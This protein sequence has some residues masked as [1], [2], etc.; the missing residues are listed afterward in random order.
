MLNSSGP[1]YFITHLI[2]HIFFTST[3]AFWEILNWVKQ[4]RGVWLDSEG[5]PATQQRKKQEQEVWSEPRLAPSALAETDVGLCSVLVLNKHC[6][7]HVYALIYLYLRIQ[8]PSVSG[9]WSGSTAWG[10]KGLSYTHA[11]F[12]LQGFLRS[13]FTH[14]LQTRSSWPPPQPLTK[15][16]I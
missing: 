6:S 9:C 2:H 1:H 15:I 16:L 3:A 12:M 13:S 4:S 7:T 8:S 5:T 11:L 14:S 10:P